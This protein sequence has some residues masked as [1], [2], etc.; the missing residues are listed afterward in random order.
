MNQPG[1][2]T[3]PFPPPL[4]C[5]LAIFVG[6]AVIAARDPEHQTLLEVASRLVGP[7]LLMR[8][9]RTSCR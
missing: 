4:R 2:R 9:A 8:L 3:A 7:E 5:N 6:L 1:G